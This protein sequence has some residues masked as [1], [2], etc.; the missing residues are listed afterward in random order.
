MSGHKEPFPPERSR[1]GARRI[2]M[3]D[4]PVLI[5]RPTAFVVRDEQD[6]KN[7]LDTRMLNLRTE[8]EITKPKPE[9]DKHGNIL[10]TLLSIFWDKPCSSRN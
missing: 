7:Q 5:I 1:P 9:R 10:T 8:V 6:L 2:V 3:V 4:M